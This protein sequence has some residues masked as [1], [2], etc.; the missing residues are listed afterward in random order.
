[1]PE[2]EAFNTRPVARESRLFFLAFGLVCLANFVYYARGFL[3]LPEAMRLI[4]GNDPILARTALISR[5]SWLFVIGILIW[6]LANIYRLIKSISQ[7]GS[8]CA[9]NPRL[10]RRIAYGALALALVSFLSESLEY[11][12]VPSSQLKLFLYKLMGV[13]MWTVLFGLAFLVIAKVFEE[14]L[15]LKEDENLTI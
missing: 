10:V 14:G 6:L 13:P 9:R 4:F 2:K 1:M 11:L 5:T 7:G 3:S 8:F 12:L 15:K